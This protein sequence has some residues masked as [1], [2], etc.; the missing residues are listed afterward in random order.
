MPDL[1]FE[2]ELDDLFGRAP[3]E[4]VATR[5]ELVRRLKADG[6]TADATTIRGWRRPTRA[7]WALNQVARSGS[8]TVAH[9]VTTASEVAD[10]QA[11]GSPGL[12]AAI[13]ELRRASHELT[14]ATF[15]AMGSG[16][17]ADREDVSAALARLV[18]DPGALGLLA[19]GRLLGVPEAGAGG[20][21]LC[22]RVG[23]VRAPRC[24]PG[25]LST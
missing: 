10:L 14:E 5:T 16:R 18:G 3:E 2:R 12:R 22:D 7:V 6:R 13:A 4:F 21:R 24:P 25:P 11:H 20:V 8:D 19:R 9:L 17:P 23:T 1:D 15:D